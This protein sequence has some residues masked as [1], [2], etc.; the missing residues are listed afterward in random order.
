MK[1]FDKSKVAPFKNITG[2]LE[3]DSANKSLLRNQIIDTTDKFNSDVYSLEQYLIGIDSAIANHTS[4]D[5]ITSVNCRHKG[6]REAFKFNLV[7]QQ[8]LNMVFKAHKQVLTNNSLIDSFD[9]TYSI[10]NT[11]IS[12]IQHIKSQIKFHNWLRTKKPEDVWFN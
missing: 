4:I 11:N 10:S 2:Y 3:G 7:M 8:V 6:H 9:L 5:N 1:Y 12:N